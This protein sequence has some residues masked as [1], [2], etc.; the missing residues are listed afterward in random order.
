RQPPRQHDEGA[1]E[2][3]R[4][5]RAAEEEQDDQ[6]GDP[7]ADHD[8]G[9]PHEELETE[10]LFHLQR[11]YGPLHGQSPPPFEESVF[12]ES[13]RAAAY[14]SATCLGTVKAHAASTSSR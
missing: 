11:Q 2:A 6:E 7:A 1:E 9:E 8:R 13:A 10:L 3:P 4:V 14:S 12:Q 5:D